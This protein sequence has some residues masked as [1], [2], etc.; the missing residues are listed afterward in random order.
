MCSGILHPPDEGAIDLEAGDTGESPAAPRCACR[1]VRI[2]SVKETL[3]S[4]GDSGTLVQW[5]EAGEGVT[6][7]AAQRGDNKREL[8]ANEIGLDAGSPSEVGFNCVEAF[9]GRVKAVDL[10]DSVRGASAEMADRSDS[11]GFIGR[12]GGSTGIG[13]GDEIGDGRRAGLPER[14]GT[15]GVIEVGLGE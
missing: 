10:A 12:A 2:D 3:E 4:G 11:S 8:G 15:R 14:G 1:I 6:Q 7:A 9:G 5:I 13:I